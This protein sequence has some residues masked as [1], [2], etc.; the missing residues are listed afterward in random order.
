M[1]SVK[2]KNNTEVRQHGVGYYEFSED[3]DTR[4]KEMQDLNDIHNEVRNIL[5][6]TVCTTA[7]IYI[8]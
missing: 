6:D 1:K 8:R 4:K 5:R 3:S 7:Y 2:S